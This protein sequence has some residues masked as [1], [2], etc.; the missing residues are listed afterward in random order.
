M[1]PRPAPDSDTQPYWDGLAGGELHIQRCRS[2]RRFQHFPAPVCSSCS[3]LDLDFEEVSGRGQIDSFVV[4]H[5]VTSPAFASL[6]PYPVAWVE[7]AEQQHLRVFGNIVDCPIDQVRL[8][9]PV[10]AIIDR[11]DPTVGP[12]LRFRLLQED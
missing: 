5:H 9:S 7:L 12:T 10:E 2:C 3:S 8:G 4:I 6:A 11:S 1:I